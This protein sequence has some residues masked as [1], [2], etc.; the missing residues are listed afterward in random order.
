M[1]GLRRLLYRKI[2]AISKCAHN[3]TQYCIIFVFETLRQILN[4]VDNLKQ[5]GG[6][7]FC[8]T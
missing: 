8:S 1:R 5:Y 2:S 4:Y 7:I 6:T 3:I